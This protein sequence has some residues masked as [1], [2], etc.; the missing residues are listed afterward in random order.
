MPAPDPTALRGWP[1]LL[2]AGAI[3]LGLLAWGVGSAVVGAYVAAMGLGAAAGLRK[4]AASTAAWIAALGVGAVFA[5][6]VGLAIED[7]V[8][9]LAGTGGLMNRVVAA[10]IAGGA[11]AATLGGVGG[12]LARRLLAHHPRAHRRDRLAGAAVGA[13]YGAALALVVSWVALSIE[14]LAQTRLATGATAGRSASPAAR[15]LVRAAKAIRE[16]PLAGFIAATNPLREADL[17]ALAADFVAVSRDPAAMEW[18]MN[19]D[20]MRRVSALESVRSGMASVRGDPAL[21]HVFDDG[22]LSLSDVVD[23][24]N[25]RTVL[26]VFDRTSVLA[27]LAPLSGAMAEALRQARARIAPPP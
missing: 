4:G 10:L 18:F 9:T 26:E 19:T 12:A 21:A 23:V 20:A 14:P 8:S 3:V 15:A 2:V 5:A 22:P 17:L 16:S 24:L 11:I 27:D 6:P 13:A 7:Q 1:S 25:N